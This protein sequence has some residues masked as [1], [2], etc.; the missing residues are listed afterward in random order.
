V[1]SSLAACAHL[2]AALLTLHA[3]DLPHGF[4]RTEA[5]GTAGAYRV[6]FARPTTATGLQ[7]GPLAIFSSAAVHGDAAAARTALRRSIPRGVAGLAVGYRLGDEAHEYV[8]QLGSSVGALLRYTLAWRD[9]PFDASVTV[10]G[11]VGV[12]SAA[13]L[14]PLARAQEARMVTA[15]RRARRSCPRRS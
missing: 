4:A 2:S 1:S 5:S 13:D 12:V 7:D 10:V 6:E 15:A 3:G 9:G 11:R 14:A 8:V